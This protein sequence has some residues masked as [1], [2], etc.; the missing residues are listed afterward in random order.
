MNDALSLDSINRNLCFTFHLHFPLFVHVFVYFILR[1][2]RS[3][4]I[5]TKWIEAIQK[6]QHFDYNRQNFHVCRR[7]FWARDFSKEGNTTALIPDAVPSV[8]EESV[9]VIDALDET[10]CM[11]SQIIGDGIIDDAINNNQCVQCPF[12]KQ[13]VQDLKKE[14]STL[15]IQHEIAVQKFKHQINLLENRNEQELDQVKQF[16]K[17]LSQKKREN[18]RLEEVIEELKNQNFISTEDEKLLNV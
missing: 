16:R 1:V 6:H 2:P 14:I 17:Q 13:K 15:N 5:R 18:V 10:D 3:G 7:H 8:F 12:L 9:V 4:D 11:E